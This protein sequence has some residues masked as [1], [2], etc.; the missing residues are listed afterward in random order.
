MY[1]SLIEM[2]LKSTAVL[3]IYS[4]L[5]NFIEIFVFPEPNFLFARALLF[6]VKYF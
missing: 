1:Y 5:S 6:S 3:H 4:Y 2:F